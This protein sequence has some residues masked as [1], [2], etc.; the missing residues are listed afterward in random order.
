MLP[1]RNFGLSFAASLVAVVFLVGCNS[2]GNVDSRVVALE[3]KAATLQAKVTELESKLSDL[4]GR[5][6]MN[7]MFKNWEGIA[8]LTPG[9]K[10]YSVVRMD[11]GNLTV[12]L[13]NIVPYANGSKA[14]LQF[15]NLT[16]AAID[17]L[18]AK[19]EWGPTDKEGAPIDK[20]AKSKEFDATESLLPG[21]WNSTEIV[22]DGIPPTSLGFVRVSAVS[23]RAIRMRGR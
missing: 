8:Y 21:A 15:G 18:K 7:Q 6:E 2:S 19:I 9:S 14:T 17:G 12:S 16:C 23:H 22:L 5:V 11:L 20:E 10:A 13:A 3:S 1:S 4:K